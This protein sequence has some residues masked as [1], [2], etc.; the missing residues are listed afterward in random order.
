M[1]SAELQ[2]HSVSSGS[3][4]LVNADNS[5]KA[6]ASEDDFVPVCEAYCDVYMERR[7]AALLDM[8]MKE[9]NGWGAIAPVSGW[10][11]A[12]LQ[13]K[14]WDDSMRD[15][16]ELFTRQYVAAPGHSEHET[17][18]AIDLGLRKEKIDFIRPE[19]PDFGVCRRFSKMA[20]EFGFILRY[21]EGKEHITG[22]AY[23]PWHFRYVGIPH[24]ELMSAL[25]LTLEEYHDFVKRFPYGEPPLCFEKKN[26]VFEISYL[27]ADCTKE[28]MHEVLE[29]A[30]GMV[31]G[32]N[33]DGFIITA[34]KNRES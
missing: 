25:G 14:I 8:L 26:I 27:R 2:R 34:W 21:P 12:Q 10:R 6:A 24:A 17:G 29:S 20:S 22:I 28:K 5:Y 23:E 3:L 15:K 7:A 32:N 33:S 1:K 18:L 9:I 30:H 16:G 11:T 13:K 4:I 19:F 31:S